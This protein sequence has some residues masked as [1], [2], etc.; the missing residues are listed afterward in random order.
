LARKDMQR[1]DDL[2]TKTI[3]GG[4][5]RASG[6]HKFLGSAPLKNSQISAENQYFP[7]E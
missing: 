4:E 7:G 2:A 1:G 5:A 6:A 3:Q